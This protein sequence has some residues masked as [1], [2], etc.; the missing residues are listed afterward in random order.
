MPYVAQCLG[1]AGGVIVA[2]SD[3]VKALPDGIDRWLPRHMTSL[4]TDGFGRSESRAALRDFFEN[5]RNVAELSIPKLASLIITHD[6]DGRFPGLKE[7]ARTD[8]P[9]VGPATDAPG[10]GI[11]TQR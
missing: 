11:A 9:P 2:A 3:Y 7:F 1:E 6:L 10:S 8:R 5:E 4:G